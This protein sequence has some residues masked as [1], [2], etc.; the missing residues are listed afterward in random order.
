MYLCLLS[1]FA[2][3][4]AYR[5]VTSIIASGLQA[6]FGI[7]PDSLGAFAG[8]FGLSFGVAQLLMGIG[9]DLYGLRRT[10]LS[11]FPLA[12][13]GA[14]LSAMA[15]SYGWLMLGQ[16]LIGVGC[17]PAFLASTVFI[18]RHFPPQ[19]FAFFSGAGM[20]V[21]GLGLL[22][23][24]TPLAWM[25]QHGGWRTGFAVLAVLSAMAWLLIFL[26]VHEPAL[27][28]APQGPRESW[29]Q[30]AARFGSLL[31]VRHTW[32]ILILG[33]SCYAAF[34]TLRG[35]WLGPLLMGRYGFSLIDSGNV[36]LVLSMLSLFMPAA[37]GRMDPGPA[38]RRRWITSFSLLMGSLFLLLAF[39]HHAT[40]SVLLIFFMGLLSG[41]GVLQYA[42]VRSSYPAEMTGRALSLY[43]M[44]MFLGVALMQ[45]FTG[46][47][48]AWAQRHG[49]EPYQ[50]VMLSIACMLAVAST[51][52]RF[53]PRSPL[54]GRGTA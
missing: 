18:A 24:G 3:S 7:S 21:G 47:L 34:L 14:A 23:T 28:Q 45:W 52:F 48:A 37:F 16:L 35:L 29:T 39:W 31:K 42:D 4:Q 36:A 32:G 38:R 5:S 22:F 26:R 43:T 2:L 30:A 11:A 25:V 12:V 13:L 15:P 17:S 9:M 41:Y 1:A 10:V 20:G 27:P 46:L 19:R 33:M 6:D 54:L 53:L 8:L 50:V 49:H 51:A 44:S 40:A